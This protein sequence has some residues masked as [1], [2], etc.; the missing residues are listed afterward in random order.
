MTSNDVQ[1]QLFQ[2]YDRPQVAHLRC[3]KLALAFTEAHPRGWEGT[4][5]ELAIAL[6]DVAEPLRLASYVPA[7]GAAGFLDRHLTAHGWTV[8]EHRKAKSRLVCVR[9]DGR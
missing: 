7:H 5:T 9:R 1:N 6:L 4:P 3:L 2:T 8:H